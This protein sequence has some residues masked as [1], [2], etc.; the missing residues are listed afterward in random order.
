MNGPLSILFIHM[1]VPSYSPIKRCKP[2][3]IGGN[4]FSPLSIDFVFGSESWSPW[5]A[6]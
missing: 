6:A 3:F 4:D 1:A 5:K 2:N